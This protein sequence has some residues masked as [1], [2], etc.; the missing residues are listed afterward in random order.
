MSIVA[1]VDFGTLNV[2]VS[3][4]GKSE[5]KLGSGVAE[6]PLH[7]SPQDPNVA[8]QSHGAQMEALERAM[9]SAL[10]ACHASGDAVQALALDTTGSSVIPVGE[11]LEPLDDYYLWCDHRAWH[12]AQEITTAAHAQGLE[13]IDWCGGV[14]SSEW[15]FSK[16]LHWL[17]H[18]PEKRTLFVTA[19]ENCDMVVATLCGITSPADLP[20]SICAMGHKWMWNAK[21]GGLP[22]DAFLSSVDPLLSGMR[23]KVAG[24]YETSDHIAGS[25]SAKWAARLG[26]R[27]GIPI[28]VGALD[29]HWDAVAANIHLGDV[30]N[31][32]GTSTCIIGVSEQQ[33]LVPGVCGVVPGSVLPKYTGIEAGLSAVGDIFDGIARRAKSTVAALTNG[34]EPYRAGQTGL[35]RM[36]WDNGDRTILVNPNL[37]GVTLGWNLMHTAQDELFAAI[38]GTALHTRIILERMQERGSPV[39]R[40]INGGGIPQKNRVLNQVYANALNKP[41]LVP[42]GD[43]TSLGSAI[44][45]FL[46]SGDYVSVEEA[47]AALCPACETF[48]P[49]EQEAAIYS[50]LYV[51]YRQLYFSLGEPDSPGMR[52][53]HI[54]PTLRAIAA[55][56]RTLE[57]E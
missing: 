28:P 21:W 19:L 54:L 2:R 39:N 41:V 30:V 9:R 33:T 26:L 53:G 15:G 17:R 27:A 49:D 7:R 10:K 37:G 12:E 32:I 48:L 55:N 40:L 3:L 34:L 25:L 31:V 1:G 51:L 45:A 43:V 42:S 36:T 22:S 46:A 38:E 24:R 44:F 4:F 14:Y 16:L 18:N 5:G 57:T 8:T 11:G 56:A 13:A 23:E 47:Q 20:R 35:L 6:Y 29:A 52:L 50:R